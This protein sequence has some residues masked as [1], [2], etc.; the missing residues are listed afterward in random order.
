MKTQL[1]NRIRMAILIMVMALFLKSEVQAQPGGNPSLTIALDPGHGGEED[2]AYYY[3]VKEKDVNLTV[4][5]L[6]QKELQQ[7][8]G[9]TVVLTRDTDEAVGLSER[10]NRANAAKADIFISLHF[11]ASVTHKSNGASVYISTMES[12]REELQN[13]ADNLLGEFE[14]IGLENAGTFA[15]VTQMGG[16]RGDGSFDDYYG[17]LRHSSNNGIP[18]VLI[19]HCYMDSEKDRDFMKSK[20]GLERLAKADANGIAA[21]YHLIKADGTKSK[22]KHASVFGG[23]TKAIQNN[24]F[25]APEIKEVQLL[26]Y[27]G[28]TPGIAK[29]EVKVED[30]IG[31]S[32]IYFVY[33]NEEGNSATVSLKFGES[34]TTGTHQAE[35]YIPEYLALG[36]YQLSYIGA[37]N[38]SGYDAGYNYADGKMIGFGKCKWLNTFE[39]NGKADLKIEQEGSISTAHAKMIEYEIKTGLRDRRN[40]YPPSS[41][42]PN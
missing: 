17:V 5:K 2:G 34:L 13:L 9:I 10:V 33:K 37:Y 40:L 31:I 18:S 32:S 16:R 21:Y 35:A 4:A 22:A 15:R 41:I 14:A 20:K 19:E 29:Y 23:T 36:D 1:Y 38:E 12:Y 27:D 28:K 39:Y 11:N 42:Y 24:Y 8:P 7:Y 3:G 30:E 26:Q 6:V 25:E